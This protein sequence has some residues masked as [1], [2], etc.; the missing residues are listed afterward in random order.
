MDCV[1]IHMPKTVGDFKNKF[2]DM[3]EMWQ[4]PYCWTAIDD[5]HIPIK[6]PPG[7]LSSCKVF[8]FLKNFYSHDAIIFQ[9]TLIWSDAKEGE[10]IPQMATNLNGVFV[11]PLVV[12]DS[13]F[14]M[15][16]WLMPFVLP[17][18]GISI[19]ASAGEEWL[20][21]CDDTFF[22]NLLQSVNFFFLRRDHNM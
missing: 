22:C 4:F 12:G 21:K 5:C 6:C 13:A 19:I 14:R 11:P 18:K 1:S 10:L 16:P 3:E 17:N 9:S 2:L 8:F 7:G 15:Q 20:L